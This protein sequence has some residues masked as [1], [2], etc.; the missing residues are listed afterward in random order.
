M[1]FAN[2]VVNN[3]LKI[4]IKYFTYIDEDFKKLTGKDINENRPNF[5]IGAMISKTK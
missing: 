2:I 5:I 4:P 3:P 1:D